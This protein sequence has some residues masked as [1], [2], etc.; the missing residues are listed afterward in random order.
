ML[1]RNEFE[2]PRFPRKGFELP[3]LCHSETF[4]ITLGC[5]IVFT[6]DNIYL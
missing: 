2:L 5:L 1:P 6:H 4:D 3:V